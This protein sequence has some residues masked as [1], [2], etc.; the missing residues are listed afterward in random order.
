[1]RN[2][3]IA[4]LALG[5]TF[6]VA[7]VGA[8]APT[9]EQLA[10]LDAELTPIGAERAGSD[11][12]VIPA[13]TG[14][15]EKTPVDPRLGYVDPFADDKILFTITAENAEE[16]KGLL[17]AGH[18]ALLKRDPDTFRMNVYPTRRS[19][20]HPEE[21]LAEVRKQATLA[22][23]DGYHIYDVGR[24][25]VPF[26]IPSDGLQVM[27]NHVFRWRGGSVERRFVWAPV[28]GNGMFYIVRFHQNIAFDQQGYMDQLREGRLY[29]ASS[30]LL[31]PPATLGTRNVTWEP[32]D[33]V[34]GKRARWTFLFQ[35]M[36]TR[37]LPAYDYNTP[38]PNTNGLRLADQTDGWNG[39]PDRYDWKLIGKRELLIGYNGYKLTDK[40][41]SYEDIVKPHHPDPDL[42]RY[43]V[44][45]VWEVEATLREGKYHTFDRRVFYLDEDTWQ[46]AQEESYVKNGAL[47]RFAD[48]Q[49]IQHYDVQVPWYAATINHDMA[50][51]GYVIGYLNNME[52]FPAR[53]GFMGHLTDYLPNHM[54]NMGITVG[55]STQ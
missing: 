49:M 55:D 7:G 50:S 21:V 52:S 27:W 46:V 12:G 25:A 11:D 30:Y 6:W 54:R 51:G 40:K 29:H 15:L 47:A 44:H 5:F 38:E 22:R 13:W 3:S 34:T 17:S 41:L 39:A 14:G 28:A 23:T 26:P 31:S 32:I 8:E 24:T 16:Y 20:A 33:A 53:W 36:R 2:V 35:S 45:R 19:A 10:R 4:S 9:V 42:L 48:Y 43:E 1:M 37:R 18:M